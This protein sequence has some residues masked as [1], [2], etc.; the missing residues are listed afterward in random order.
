MALEN[1]MSENQPGELITRSIMTTNR[2]FD[3][4]DALITRLE[5]QTGKKISRS[6][7]ISLLIEVI[8][9]HGELIDVNQIYN[10]QTLEEQ[11]ARAIAR[12][13][14]QNPEKKHRR[15]YER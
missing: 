15:A 14:T 10:D 13:V 9:K 1:E 2:V 4:L 11:L 5:G 8:L 12:G 3:E 7:F 6:R